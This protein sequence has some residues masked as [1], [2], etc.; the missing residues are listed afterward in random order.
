MIKLSLCFID[1]F[2]AVGLAGLA[3][4]GYNFDTVK[5]LTYCRYNECC[6]DDYIPA[7]IYGNFEK[8][9]LYFNFE[10]NIFFIFVF[11]FLLIL[12]KG[13][14]RDLKN[15][16]YGQ[17]I[18]V[19]HLIPALRGQ[20]NNNRQ[21]KKPL[22][23]SFHGTPGTGKNYVSDFI[24]NRLYKNGLQSRYVYK[25]LG[26]AD[27][28]LSSQSSHYGAELTRKVR[29]AIM[30]CPRSL[31]IFDEVDKM[32]PGVFES[33]T[34]LLDHHTYLNGYDFRQAT[35]IFLSNTAG[36]AISTH[37]ADLMKQG[38]WRED[39]QLQDFEK[40]IE[41]GAYNLQGGLQKASIIESHLIDHYIPF[42]PL[43]K[44]HVKKCII[45]EYGKYVLRAPD[46]EKIK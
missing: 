7:D 13:L 4:L 16:L 37:L 17:H 8:Q 28:P 10:N 34:S 23:I 1:P 33:L 45:E 11:F 30:L 14:E 2:T 18:V 36:V 29:D 5:K 21:S 20:F 15:K 25:F 31:F 32:P 44:E 39:T 42:L 24:A 41:I 3:A 27:F 40:I 26:R 38:K 22:V 9:I 12:Y 46:E 43:E 35:F 19:K 6:I